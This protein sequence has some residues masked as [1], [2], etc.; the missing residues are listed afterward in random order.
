[1][2][3]IQCLP[4]ASASAAQASRLIGRRF[5][6]EDIYPQIDCGRF[7]VKRIVRE[8][9]HVWADILRDG[10][11]VLAAELKWR[12]ANEGIWNA[13]LMRFHE[14]DRWSGMFIPEVKGRYVYAIEAWTDRFSTWRR[15]YL[16]KRDAGEDITSEFLLGRQILDDAFVN[17]NACAA[18]KEAAA[19]FDA[20]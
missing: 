5:C 17:E 2:N 8:P 20:T 18:I 19:R 13:S 11:D 6:I 1:M 14:N 4:K 16:L 15:N 3:R 12:R 10:H 9:F 7:P